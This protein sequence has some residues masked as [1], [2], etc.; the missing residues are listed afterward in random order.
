MAVLTVTTGPHQGRII[1]LGVGG[2]T[3]TL[4]R[5]EELPT[6]I[7][8]DRASRRHLVIRADPGGSYFLKDLNSTNGTFVNVQRVFFEVRLNDGDEI[9]MGGTTLLFTTQDFTSAQE[10]VD[11]AKH[12]GERRRDTIV[13]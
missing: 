11:H 7:A 4:G 6:Q 9:R 2:G 1:A 13:R 3:L 5:D 12:L 8:D 10:A